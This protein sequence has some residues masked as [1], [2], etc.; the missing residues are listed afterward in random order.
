MYTWYIHMCYLLGEL[1][2]INLY[3][4]DEFVTIKWQFSILYWRIADLNA[5]EIE[6]TPLSTFRVHVFLYLMMLSLDYKIFTLLSRLYIN[7]C[8][9]HLH[10]LQLR[11][12]SKINIRIFGTTI[13]FVFEYLLMSYKHSTFLIKCLPVRLSFNFIN[14]HA[15]GMFQCMNESIL[16]LALNCRSFYDNIHF[17]G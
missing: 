4:V 14:E 7:Q 5:I 2:S 6:N 9:K 16:L 15:F 8:L 3:H 10:L 11:W 13:L 1:H 12:V 17:Y